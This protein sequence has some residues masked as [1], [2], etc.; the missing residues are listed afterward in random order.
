MYI[1]TESQRLHKV[2]MKVSRSSAK[3][4]AH[5]EGSMAALLPIG[6]TRVV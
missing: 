6:I 3:T 5:R 4:L 2:L 1:D